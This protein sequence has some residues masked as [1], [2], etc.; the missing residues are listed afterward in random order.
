M[1]S[2]TSGVLQ[3]LLRQEFPELDPDRITRLALRF[4]L[5]TPEVDCMLVGMRTEAEVAVNAALAAEGA[6]RCDLRALHDFFDG[7]PRPAPPAR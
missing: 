4:V 3:R 5:S 7:R 2:A 6:A 1:R